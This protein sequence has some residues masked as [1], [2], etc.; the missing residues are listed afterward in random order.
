MRKIYDVV[1]AANIK[2]IN[3]FESGMTGRDL[4]LIARDHIAG[5]D[6]GD[7]FSMDLVTEAFRCMKNRE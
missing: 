4:D 7:G 2:A 6:I 1:L 5:E 3:S